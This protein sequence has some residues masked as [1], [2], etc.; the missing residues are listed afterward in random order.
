LKALAASGYDVA[1]VVTQPDRPGHRGRVAPTPVKEAATARR[2]PV[3]QPGRIRDLEA[4]AHLRAARPELIVV[5]AYGQILSREIL[6]LPRLGAVNVHASLLPRWRGA[7]PVSRAILAGD[8]ITG[9][10]IMRMD[11]E[12]DHGPILAAREV[13]IAP[14]DDAQ[15]LT[16]R[17]AELGADLLLEVIGDLERYPTSEQGHDRATFAPRLRKEEGQLDWTLSASEIDRRVRAL[18]PWPG[19]S[20]ELNGRRVKLLRGRPLGGG[21]GAAPGTI[22]GFEHGGVVMATGDGRYLIEEVQLP[23]RRPMSPKQLVT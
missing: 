16:E 10:T 8:A 2:L 6:E 15:S 13:A 23:G 9:V 20:V 7:A 1:L 22:L 17:L 5:A 18:R 14:D 11:E 3:Y 12:L 19:T 4:V 21:A